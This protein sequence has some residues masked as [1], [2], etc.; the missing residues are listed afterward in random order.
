[1]PFRKQE[2]RNVYTV[3]EQRSLVLRDSRGAL[4]PKASGKKRKEKKRKE[5]KRKEK[6][7]KLVKI[8]KNK[9][10]S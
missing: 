7:R 5:K 8:D 3:L 4:S 2:L 10:C 1:L 6:K 9:Q